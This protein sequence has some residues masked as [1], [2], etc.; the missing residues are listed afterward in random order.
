MSEQLKQA[1][2]R[3]MIDQFNQDLIIRRWSEWVAGDG[4]LY[5]SHG[6]AVTK[7]SASFEER[8]GKP[9]TKVAKR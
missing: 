2:Q 8:T 9:L 1:Q 5:S 7:L 4:T 3:K 6:A